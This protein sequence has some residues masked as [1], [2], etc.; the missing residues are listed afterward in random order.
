MK[1]YIKFDFL[2]SIWRTK[3]AHLWSFWIRN[4]F[5]QKIIY[6]LSRK[7]NS[8]SI[9]VH[10]RRSWQIFK[11]AFAPEIKVGVI[12]LETDSYNPQKWWIS[13]AGVKAIITETIGYIYTCFFDNWYYLNAQIKRLSRD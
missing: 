5:I 9:D 13:N 6:I 2:V 12:V 4:L 11:Q 1:S 8:S 7:L 10:S 3:E